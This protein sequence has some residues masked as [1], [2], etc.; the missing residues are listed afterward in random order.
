VG[1]SFKGGPDASLRESRCAEHGGRCAVE[2]VSRRLRGWPGC[3]GPSLLVKRY[4]M[5]KVKLRA[6][7]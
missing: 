4:K 7:A 3:D 5:T 2:C 1:L 6:D